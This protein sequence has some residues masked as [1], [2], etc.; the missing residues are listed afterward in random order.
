MHTVRNNRHVTHVGDFVHETADLRRLSV[1]LKGQVFGGT[2]G[3]ANLVYRKT[4]A[5]NCQPSY[6][7]YFDTRLVL[8]SSFR[9]TLYLEVLL[10]RSSIS[11]ANV[12]VLT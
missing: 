1:M 9:I 6:P 10:E 11:K 7:K 12:D 5:Q 3:K 4:V 2:G 8:I